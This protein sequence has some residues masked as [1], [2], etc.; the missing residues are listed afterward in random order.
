[1]P[2]ISLVKVGKSYGAVEVCRDINLTIADREFVT[3]LGS[4]GCGKT[5]TLNMIGG[6]DEVTSGDILMDGRRVN[7]SSR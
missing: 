3:L 5:T 2:E 6:L 1:M 7:D 4:S